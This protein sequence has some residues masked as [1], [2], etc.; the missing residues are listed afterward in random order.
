MFNN[1]VGPR[2]V[3][4]SERWLKDFHVQAQQ[5]N[6][7]NVHLLSP[8]KSTFFQQMSVYQLQQFLLVVHDTSLCDNVGLH[9]KCKQHSPTLGLH[10]TQ[11]SGHRALTLLVGRQEGHPACKKL[12]VGLLV[13]I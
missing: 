10:F 4:M 3:R 8:E 9:R 12:D 11:I 7:D 1:A 13:V 6:T 2:L 5:S